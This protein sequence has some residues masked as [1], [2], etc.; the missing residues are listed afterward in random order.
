MHLQVC[1]IS[2]SAPFLRVKL[3]LRPGALGAN[4]PSVQLAA[5]SFSK[6]AIP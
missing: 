6:P 3:V 4:I 1:R 5:S 2:G